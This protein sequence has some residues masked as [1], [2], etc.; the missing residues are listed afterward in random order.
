MPQKSQNPKPPRS[1][2]LFRSPGNPRPSLTKMSPSSKIT[3]PPIPVKTQPSPLPKARTIQVDPAFK[4]LVSDLFNLTNSLKSDIFKCRQEIRILRKDFYD[5]KAESR[6]LRHDISDLQGEISEFHD[7]MTELR[8]N[9]EESRNDIEEFR[10]YVDEFK[11]EVEM[12]RESEGDRGAQLLEAFEGLEGVVE[13]YKEELMV[14]QHERW[15]LGRNYSVGGADD[16]Y[17]YRRAYFP[18]CR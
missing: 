7:G 4:T 3:L 12:F 17:A 6:S 10:G 5:F 18:R 15:E 11:E 8:D 2:R 1:P 14:L 13:G 16:D 9:V